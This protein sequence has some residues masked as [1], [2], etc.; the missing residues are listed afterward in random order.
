MFVFSNIVLILKNI[1][2]PLEIAQENMLSREGRQ[3]VELVHDA[4]EESLLKEVIDNYQ[5]CFLELFIHVFGVLQRL[6]L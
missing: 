2:A 6:K 4:V 3:G 1:E 5:T